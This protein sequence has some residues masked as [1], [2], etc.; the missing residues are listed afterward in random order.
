ML[1]G[2]QKTGMPCESGA[3]RDGA[4]GRSHGKTWYFQRFWQI[5]VVF[6][7]LWRVPFRGCEEHT[8]I[9]I[10]LWPAANSRGI[11]LYFWIFLVPH[12]QK[13]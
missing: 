4:G 7:L 1:L 13:L 8:Q 3:L 11:T 5:R 6:T 12:F 10:K 2:F 9:Y